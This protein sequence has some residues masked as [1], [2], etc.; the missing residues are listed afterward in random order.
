MTKTLRT[1][2]LALLLLAPGLLA[3]SAP[4]RAQGT[5]ITIIEAISA[6][7]ARFS[8]QV[9]AAELVAARPEE[10]TGS[11]YAFRLLTPAGDILAIRVDAENGDILE[12]DGRGLVAARRRAMGF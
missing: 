7:T 2:A 6:A 5:G 11:V 9:I 12:V 10:L 3:L 1:I 4:A 8:G